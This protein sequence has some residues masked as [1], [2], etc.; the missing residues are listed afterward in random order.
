MWNGCKRVVAVASAYFSALE[1]WGCSH[2]AWFFPSLA[3]MDLFSFLDDKPT[4]D[5]D[6]DGDVELPPADAPTALR[7]RRASTPSTNGHGL[8]DESAINGEPSTK[9]A[10]AATPPPVVLDEFETEAKRE[11]AASAGLAGPVEAG[12]RLELRHQVSTHL[13]A[14]EAFVN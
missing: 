3:I 2:L 14:V 5:V 6:E 12:S 9:K 8:D 13:L 4:D 1:S 7:K 11:V 10:R